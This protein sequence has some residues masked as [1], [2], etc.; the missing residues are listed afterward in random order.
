M[1]RPKERKPQKGGRYPGVH[2]KTLDFIEH[3]FDEG[4]LYLHIRFRDQ[5]E[6]SFVLGAKLVLKEADLSD[7]STGDYKLI[8]EYKAYEE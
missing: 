3:K 7:I 4:N 6:V 1:A 8:Q 5:T 2:G